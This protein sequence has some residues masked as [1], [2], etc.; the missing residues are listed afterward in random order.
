MDQG[1]FRNDVIREKGLLKVLK[2]INKLL[3]IPLKC[4]KFLE[5]FC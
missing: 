3:I 1:P 5:I 2:V 4:L